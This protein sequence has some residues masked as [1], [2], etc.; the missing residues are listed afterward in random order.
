MS[1][2]KTWTLVAVAFLL[3]LLVGWLW[4][5]SAAPHPVASKS[6]VANVAPP[7][8]S[9]QK[10]DIRFT[11]YRVGKLETRDEQGH[12]H[13][14]HSFDIVI[15]NLKNPHA[16]LDSLSIGDLQ[17]FQ[18]KNAV[19]DPIRTKVN[20]KFTLPPGLPE[21]VS[22]DALVVSCYQVLAAPSA[23]ALAPAAT[24]PDGADSDAATPTPYE[25]HFTYGLSKIPVE[26]GP[27][28]FP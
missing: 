11:V 12:T 25:L 13:W 9:A 28:Q 27:L 15:E 20:D 7:L 22:E 17:L 21:S 1:K 24:E 2:G 8:P 6:P 3:G 10:G 23:T 4:A 14:L 26:L 16:S 18:G 19:A 5:V